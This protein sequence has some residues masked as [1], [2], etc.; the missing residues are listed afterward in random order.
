[1]LNVILDF[2]VDEECNIQKIVLFTHIAQHT[3]NT[4]VQVQ[5]KHIFYM[6]QS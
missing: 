6:T 3:F 4:D 2:N 1:M 5:V